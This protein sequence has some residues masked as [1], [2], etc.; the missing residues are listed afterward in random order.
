MWKQS[1]MAHFKVLYEHLIG[2]IS[3]VK[4]GIVKIKLSLVKDKAIPATGSR[5]P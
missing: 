5:G 3:N 1:V 4:L 2:G